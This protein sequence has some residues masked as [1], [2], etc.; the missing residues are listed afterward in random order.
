M[1]RRRDRAPM[2]VRS[3]QHPVTVWWSLRPGTR[4]AV[5]VLGAEA[6]LGTIAAAPAC[7]AALHTATLHF[8]VAV[9]VIPVRR[10]LVVAPDGRR[11][12]LPGENHCVIRIAVNMNE[13]DYRITHWREVGRVRDRL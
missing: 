10:T 6:A 2:I 1:S 4:S 5:R 12:H 9:Y 3:V 7:F 8:H 11:N 13:E